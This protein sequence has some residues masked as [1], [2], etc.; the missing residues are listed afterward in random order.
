MDNQQRL[1]ESIE[2]LLKQELAS[3]EQNQRRQKNI[4]VFVDTLKMISE[5]PKMIDSLYESAA[6]N[7]YV[8]ENDPMQWHGTFDSYF[9]RFK[10]PVE[11]IVSKKSSF[12]AARCYDGKVCVLNFASS[13]SPGGGVVTGSTAQEECL[14]RASTLYFNLITEE[15]EKYFYGPHKAESNDL[16]TNDLIY[17]P[18]VKIIKSDNYEK[19]ETP[20]NVNVITCAAPKLKTLQ[21]SNLKLFEIHYERG[22]RIL[23]VALQNKNDHL[24]LGAFGC[25][26]F[27]NSPNVVAKAYKRLIENKFKH[28]FK[29]IEFAIYC[30]KES[31]ENNYNAFAKI[32]NK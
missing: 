23:D 16:A 6:A 13:Y 2:S 27:K 31:D 7:Q 22:E 19:L 8:K 32:F 29:T 21:I 3:Y 17:S 28:A 20:F 10:E 9:N 26:V 4:D 5:D 12:D 25:G 14:C 18:D 30:P 1:L 11:I 15:A 24:I